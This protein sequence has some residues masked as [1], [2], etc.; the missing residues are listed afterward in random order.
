MARSD[1]EREVLGRVGS[2]A[3]L[4]RLL[5]VAPAEANRAAALLLG[6]EAG[7]GGLADQRTA[8]S[9]LVDGEVAVALPHVCKH[10]RASLDS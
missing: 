5:A 3:R 9:R 6:D 4:T 10:T 2:R 7:G 8:V 1:T